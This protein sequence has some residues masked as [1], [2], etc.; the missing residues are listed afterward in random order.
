MKHVEKWWLPV[1]RRWQRLTKRDRA[2]GD[3]SDLQ[4]LELRML[5]AVALA[6]LEYKNKT[7]K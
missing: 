6:V 2:S 3:L 7:W 4:K 5:R 1:E